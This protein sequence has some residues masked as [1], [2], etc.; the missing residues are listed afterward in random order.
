M[1]RSLFCGSIRF[2]SNIMFSKYFYTADM[3]DRLL[4]THAPH[5]QH[6]QY[7]GTLVFCGK[8]T[9]VARYT[10]KNTANMFN[11]PSSLERTV[12]ETVSTVQIVEKYVVVSKKKHYQCTHVGGTRFHNAHYFIV[13]TYHFWVNY[14]T[15]A[16]MF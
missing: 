16:G 7:T 3:H 5:T 10:Y 1:I 9:L 4:S 15:Q 13:F 2:K 14:S 6:M 8:N 12:I 11:Y